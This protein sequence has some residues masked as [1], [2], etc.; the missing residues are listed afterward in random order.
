MKKREGHGRRAGLTFVTC[1]SAIT[2]CTLGPAQATT[3]AD[4]FSLSAPV[5]DAMINLSVDAVGYR[6]KS[7][8]RSGVENCIFQNLKDFILEADKNFRSVKAETDETYRKELVEEII[9]RMIHGTCMGPK[10][11]S[12]KIAAPEH[13]LLVREFF[14]KFPNSADKVHIVGIA[15][16]T[17]A[18]FDLIDGDDARGKCAIAK[19]LSG[20]NAP[21]FGELVSTLRNEQSSPNTTVEEV[22]LML[23]TKH[24]G[25]DAYQNFMNTSRAAIGFLEEEKKKHKKAMK[26]T[27]AVLVEM[28]K[29]YVSGARRESNFRK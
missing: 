6:M 22:L 29:T 10:S 24:C 4:V 25:L 15:I 8:E 27:E 5:Y 1:V 9:G 11:D 18:A 26:E 13:H 12:Y 21:G 3:V 20:K 19:F 17:Q 23:I 16:G 2:W 7:E 14:E 28:L